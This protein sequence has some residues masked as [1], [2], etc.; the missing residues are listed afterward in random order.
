M[1]EEQL[2]QTEPLVPSHLEIAVEVMLEKQ[3]P[4]VSLS[5][6]TLPNAAGAC[7]EYFTD[8]P[9]LT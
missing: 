4:Q 8:Q 2:N 7:A 9:A 5:P 3:S 6:W 1:A